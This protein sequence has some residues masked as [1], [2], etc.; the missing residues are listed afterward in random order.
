[1]QFLHLDQDPNVATKINAALDPQPWYRAILGSFIPSSTAVSNFLDLDELAYE[2]PTSYHP[3]IVTGD[4]NV[5][6]YTD[7]YRL[8]TKGTIHPQNLFGLFPYYNVV[9]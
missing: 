8:I 2:S 3:T 4:F 7:I 1:M 5:E 9:D 6:P